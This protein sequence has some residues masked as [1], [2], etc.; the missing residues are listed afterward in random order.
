MSDFKLGDGMKKILLAG[1]GAVATSAEKSQEILD[2]LVKKG[3]LTV[4]QGKALNQELKHTVKE[5]G[6]KA[7]ETAAEKE[8][9]KKDIKSFVDS[10]SAEELEEL[11]KQ[12]ENAD[13][14]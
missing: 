13:K 2:E 5:A 10:L 12:I 14:E 6:K 1:V 11:K 4:E 7:E 9:E 3:E 8:P